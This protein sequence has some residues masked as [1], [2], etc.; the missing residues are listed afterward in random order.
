MLREHPILIA[1]DEVG[2]GALAGHVAVGAVVIDAP[3][4]RK[5]V[6]QGLRDSKLVPEHRRAEVAARDASWVQASAVGWAS[7]AEIDDVGIISTHTNDRTQLA[8]CEVSLFS[9]ANE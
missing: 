5:R 2:R 9:W 7:S 3:C 8:I 1:C 6:P 4:A